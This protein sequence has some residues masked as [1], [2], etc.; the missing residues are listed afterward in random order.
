MSPDL[1]TLARL[2][3]PETLALGAFSRVSPEE[4]PPTARRLLAHDEHMTETVAAFHGA[5]VDVRVLA[6]RVD[7]QRYSRKILL[8]RRGDGR[9]VMYGI[10]RIDFAQIDADAAREIREE[11]KPLG[12]VLIERDILRRVRLDTLW[13]VRP[14][15]ELA[16][17]L[18]M[19]VEQPTHGRTAIIECNGEPAIELIEIVT[20]DEDDRM[21]RSGTT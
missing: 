8:T 12:R 21:P 17:L 14:S 15:Q 1:D 9:V 2:F 4:M 18:G 20:P 16:A 6:K 13:R 11:R 10:V 3:Y 7:G 19:P 5:P